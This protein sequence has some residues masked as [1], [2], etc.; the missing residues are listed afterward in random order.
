[1][2]SPIFVQYQ[3]N[4]EDAMKTPRNFLNRM[5]SSSIFV[6]MIAIVLEE[7]KL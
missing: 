5:M 6:T 3:F 1:M 7:T 4:I 2:F